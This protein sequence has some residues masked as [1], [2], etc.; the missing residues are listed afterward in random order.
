[1]NPFVTFSSTHPNYL[2]T[3]TSSSPDISPSRL[4]FSV[5]FFY[6]TFFIVRNT[7]YKLKLQKDHGAAIN[8]PSVADGPKFQ[9]SYESSKWN[10]QPLGENKFLTTQG[11]ATRFPQQTDDY[12]NSLQGGHSLSKALD[13]FS[14]EGPRQVSSS[15]VDP[16]RLQ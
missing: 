14:P 16:S 5:F 2:H 3:K 7:I 13:M 11:F 1:M 6:H 12:P 9:G 10:E 8:N 4:F 15:S